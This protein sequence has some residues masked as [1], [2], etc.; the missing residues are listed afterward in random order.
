MDSIALVQD[1]DRR[2][3]VVSGSHGGLL[4]GIANDGILEPDAFAAGVG[5]RDGVQEHL[6][7]HGGAGQVECGKHGQHR[8]QIIVQV[9]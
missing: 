4:G 8:R 5:F 7:R 6:K 9:G 3:I 1:D 2:K